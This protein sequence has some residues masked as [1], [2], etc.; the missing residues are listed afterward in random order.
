MRS[1]HN[2]GLRLS[3]VGAAVFLFGIVCLIFL[4]ATIAVTAMLI[5]GVAA[6]GGFIWTLLSWY[7]SA[8]SPPSSPD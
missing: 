4:P 3:L 7:L 6:W 2:P 5:G 1:A 8:P